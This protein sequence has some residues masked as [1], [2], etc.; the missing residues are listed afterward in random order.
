M[1]SVLNRKKKKM[2]PLGYTKQELVSIQNYA[3]KQSKTNYLIE[4]S[5][6]NIRLIGY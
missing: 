2:Q 1:S 3:R 5:Y 4:E 6:M